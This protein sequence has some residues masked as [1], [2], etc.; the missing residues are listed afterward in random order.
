MRDDSSDAGGPHLERTEA[1]VVETPPA[2]TPDAPLDPRWWGAVTLTVGQ[3]A[4]W[5][6]GP[7][8][9]VAERRASDWRIWH[10][11]EDD[12][13][14]VVAERAHRLP[15]APPE[16][17]P[18]LRFSFAE[19]PDTITV[20]PMLADRSVIVRPE[21]ALTVPPGERVT[22]YISTPV[23]MALKLEVRRARRGRTETEPVVLAELPTYRPSDTWFGTS[24]REGEL[25][26]SVRTAAR[27]V[28]ADL[29]LRPHRAVTPVTVENQAA[30]PLAL[31][32]ISVPMPFL[33]L[34]ADR[35]G[36]LWSDGVLFVR[37]PDDDTSVKVAPY[38]PDGGERLAAP[39]S[40]QGFGQALSRTFSRL[41]KG[42][43]R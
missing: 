23:W 15:D 4:R 7:S 21:S 20:K 12:A 6:A 27:L 18:T 31:A 41:L 16:G 26:Y 25:C 1:P 32:R 30:T 5:R 3:A 14:A 36:R 28:A 11:T 19:T 2:T 42:D 29:P 17:A 34:H 37:E 8:T 40:V 43:T 38:V 13:Y 24:T 22:L 35:A 9:V 10:D 39:R 33:G